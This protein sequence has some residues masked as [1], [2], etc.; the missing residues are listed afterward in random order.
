MIDSIEHPDGYRNLHLSK[1]SFVIPKTTFA[2]CQMQKEIAGKPAIFLM[3]ERRNTRRHN[4]TQ[5]SGKP[6]DILPAPFPIGQHSKRL[7]E[8]L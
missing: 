8:A 6:Q 2:P 4:E 7:R 3:Q 5:L 1:Q